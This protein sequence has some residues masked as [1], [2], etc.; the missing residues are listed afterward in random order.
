[1][2]I[3]APMA[4]PTITPVEGLEEFLLLDVEEGLALPEPGLVPESV[5]KELTVML[6]LLV[7]LAAFNAD[8][9]VPVLA[10]IEESVDGVGWVEEEAGDEETDDTGGIFMAVPAGAVFTAAPTPA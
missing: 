1:M 5:G 3:K 9:A 10:K 6:A 8:V 7:D 4:I 2:I